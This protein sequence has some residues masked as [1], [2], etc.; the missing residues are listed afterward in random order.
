MKCTKCEK[1]FPEHKIHESHDVPCYIFKGRNRQEK[2]PQADM[3][4]RHWLC[5]KCHEEYEEGLRLSFKVRAIKFSKNFFKEVKSEGQ[6]IN[7]RDH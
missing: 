4:G 2:K 1:D 5:E 6:T 3:Y 7:T